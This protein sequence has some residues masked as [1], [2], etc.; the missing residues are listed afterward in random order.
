MSAMAVCTTS[1]LDPWL[2]RVPSVM[3]LPA[4][5]AR[6]ADSTVRPPSRYLVADSSRT[7]W[8]CGN[9][10]TINQVNSHPPRRLVSR[11]TVQKRAS[12]HQVLCR[13]TT[14]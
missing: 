9:P 3:V 2:I 1:L 14:A 8:N 12:C 7:S 6:A 10:A 4:S 11:V 5:S 13:E